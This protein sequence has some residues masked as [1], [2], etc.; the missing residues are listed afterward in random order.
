LEAVHALPEMVRTVILLRA[1]QELSYED[2]GAATGLSVAAVKVRV[3]RARAK[4]AA[5]LHPKKKETP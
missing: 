5:L 1:E 3:F 2:I 4:L